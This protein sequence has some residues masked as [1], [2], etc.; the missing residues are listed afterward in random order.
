MLH[1]QIA[2]NGFNCTKTV[3]AKLKSSSENWYSK[4]ILAQIKKLGPMRYQLSQYSINNCF[5]RACL[6]NGGSKCTK[7]FRIKMN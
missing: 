2:A 1:R 6:K 3:K 4:Q 5:E 7:K